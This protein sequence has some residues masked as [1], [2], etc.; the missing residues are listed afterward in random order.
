MQGDSNRVIAKHGVIDV[1]WPL[2]TCPVHSVENDA[3]LK[4]QKA[5]A[6]F[7]TVHPQVWLHVALVLPRSVFEP[8]F[9]FFARLLMSGLP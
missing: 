8:F 9:V 7:A 2:S 6:M 3:D 4:L 1:Y 5:N